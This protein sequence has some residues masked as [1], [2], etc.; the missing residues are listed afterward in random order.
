MSAEAMQHND[1]EDSLGLVVALLPLAALVVLAWR[2]T[3][4]SVVFGLLGSLF[5]GMSS[6]WEAKQGQVIST[7]T[8]G[9]VAGGAIGSG[10]SLTLSLAGRLLRK[11]RAR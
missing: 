11:L 2:S 9:S 5:G 4:R 8:L 6:L 3:R 10:G 1:T 7:T